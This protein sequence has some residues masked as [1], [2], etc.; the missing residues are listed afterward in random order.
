LVTLFIF[1]PKNEYNVTY[2]K[3]L[4]L[5]ELGSNKTKGEGMMILFRKKDKEAPLPQCAHIINQNVGSAVLRWMYFTGDVPSAIAFAKSTNFI[6]SSAWNGYVVCLD[7][8][9]RLIWSYKFAIPVNAVDGSLDGTTCAIGCEDGMLYMFNAQ[10]QLIASKQ[11]AHPIASIALNSNGNL[12]FLATQL[13]SVYCVAGTHTIWNFG[14]GTQTIPQIKCTPDGTR[15]IFG[16][17]L[18][19]VYCLNG[20]GELMWKYF[21][22]S[23]PVT[24]VACSIN[25]SAVYAG[26]EKGSFVKIDATGRQVWKLQ[27]GKSILRM[28][29]VVKNNCVVVGNKD[30]RVY[31]ID[32][33]GNILRTCICND[34][35]RAVSASFDG[36]FVAVGSH[37]KY[38]YLFEMSV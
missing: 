32:E 34:W 28:D 27:I 13:G 16:S 29:Y 21:V 38:I 15:I 5:S 31:Y 11:F 20:K 4:Q 30:C 17:A 6:F 37:D 24:G 26:T 35:T 3:I 2:I 25:A 1:S 7:T 10:G 14:I 12:A 19:N 22:D 18:G 9:G 36:K 23:T 33:N 8:S